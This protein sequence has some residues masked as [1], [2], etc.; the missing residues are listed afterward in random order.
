V[1][2]LIVEDDHRL[3]AVLRRGLDR[4]GFGVDVVGDGAAAL[5]AVLSTPFDVVV[6]DVMLPGYLDGF[7][8]CAE[9][10]SRRVRTPILMLTALDAVEER[11]RGLNVGADDYLVKPFALSELL[12]RL[13]ALSRRHLDDR[14]AT[15]RAGALELDTCKHRVTVDG[16]PVGLTMKEFAILELLLLHPGQLIARAQI[17]EHVWNYDFVGES[18]LVEVYIG[19]LRR[20]LAAAGLGNPIETVRHGGYRLEASSTPSATPS[21]APG[22]G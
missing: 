22:P 20:K 2:V 14:S 21:G 4:E 19:R 11:V 9:L 13:R 12:A 3:G 6:L 7:E 10:R 1:R 5:A 16:F 17:E 8:V 18:N 15:L